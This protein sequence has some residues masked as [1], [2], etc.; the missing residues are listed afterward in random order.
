M[1]PV[2]L[3]TSLESWNRIDSIRTRTIDVSLFSLMSSS[4]LSMREFEGR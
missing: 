2:A 3:I 1:S 4:A